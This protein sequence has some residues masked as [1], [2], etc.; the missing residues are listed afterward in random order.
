LPAQS[1]LE[2]PL[3]IRLREARERIGLSQR[4]LG[5]KAKI[6]PGS[7]SARINQYEQGKHAPDFQTAGR[8][9]DCLNVPVTYFYAC[10][11]NLAALILLFNRIDVRSQ[12]KLLLDV[13][14]L[15]K[16]N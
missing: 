9:A 16:D 13:E 1:P 6:D 15:T 7:A 4:E 2:S 12:Q 11:D 10:D 5:I 14:K 8:L 3:P